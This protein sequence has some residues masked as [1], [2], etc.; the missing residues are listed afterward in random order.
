MQGGVTMTKANLALAAALA[1]SCM[2]LPSAANASIV[3]NIDQ[4]GANVVVNASGSF[5]TSGAVPATNLF[6]SRLNPSIA[7]VNV[8][9]AES[10]A[11]L[12]NGFTGPSSFGSGTTTIADSYLG[13]F[14]Y[15]IGGYQSDSLHNTLGLAANYV[16][17]SAISGSAT[18]LN[19]T[20]T[21][22]GLNIGTYQYSLNGD[23][24][25]INI[26]QPGAVPEA[27]TWAMMILGMGAVGYAMRRR[28]KVTTR[29]SY[30]A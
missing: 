5:N 15:F 9:P 2:A 23:A 6:S 12:L 8:G 19:K 13:D 21:S 11:I 22:L 4:L 17:G 3:F 16:S 27:A 30:A 7:R 25:T 10:N 28:Q 24:V 14:I 20:F 18:Y 26:A 29:I 1:G